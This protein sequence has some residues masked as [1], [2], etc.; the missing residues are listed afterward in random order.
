MPV[1]TGPYVFAASDSGAYL[2]QNP[3]WWQQ[4]ALPLRRIALLHCK[5]RDTML[6]AFSSREV[7]LLPAGPHRHPV[8]PACPPAATIPTPPRL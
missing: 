1:G 2:E 5:D 4:K 8:R 7:Q 6:Y 3:S